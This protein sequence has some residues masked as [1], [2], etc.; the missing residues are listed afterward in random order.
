MFSAFSFVRY[1]ALWWTV[2]RRSF[3]AFNLRFNC[4]NKII[5][6]S[7]NRSL[8]FIVSFLGA[9]SANRFTCCEHKRWQ[10]MCSHQFY[11][12]SVW[13]TI[14]VKRYEPCCISFTVFLSPQTIYQASKLSFMESH[15]CISLIEHLSCASFW[16]RLLPQHKTAS[17]NWFHEYWMKFK[18]KGRH[19]IKQ[20]YARKVIKFLWN[21]ENG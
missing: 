2:K 7:K 12:F 9:S 4:Q 17:I 18:V 11:S 16:A 19:L 1:H 10:T 14:S 20:E 13:K 3:T 6:L 5:S 21:I 15:V 8:L